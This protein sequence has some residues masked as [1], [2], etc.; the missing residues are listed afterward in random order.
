MKQKQFLKTL[1]LSSPH[2]SQHLLRLLLL[3]VTL[4]GVVSA[5][6]EDVTIKTLDW[7]ASEWSSHSTICNTQKEET[8]NGI[9]FT[10][11]AE[12]SGDG[13][14]ISNGLLTFTSDGNIQSNNRWIAVPLENINGKITVNIAGVSGNKIGVK[15]AF[16]AGSTTIGTPSSLSDAVTSSSNGQ[17][18][19]ININDIS[20]TSGVLY[21]GR[22]SSNYTQIGNVTITTPSSTPS[23]G[24]IKNVDGTTTTWD[25]TKVTQ[26][27]GA[28]LT[29]WTEDT[30]NKYFKNPAE[31]KY[32]TPSWCDGI[33][34][35][36]KGGTDSDKVRVYYGEGTNA[37]GVNFNGNN[38]A[39]KVTIPA[40]ANTLEVYSAQT[41][42]SSDVTLSTITGGYSAIVTPGQEVV[43]YRNSGATFIT[44]VITKHEDIPTYTITYN[45]N[46]HGDAIAD[47]TEA[48]ALPSTLPTPT[49][50][51]Y[52]FGGWY[53]DEGLTNAATAGAAISANTTLYAKWTAQVY[54]IKYPGFDGTHGDNHPT[55]HTYGTATTLVNP[56]KAGY[57]F[58]GW[59]DNQEFTGSAITV[60]GAT[61][62]T[63]NI[64]LY[65]KWTA[66]ASACEISNLKFGETA[67][68]LID[69]IYTVTIAHNDL[70][71]P[72]DGKYYYDVTFNISE[73]AT[74]TCSSGTPKNDNGTWS[75]RKSLGTN[76]GDN[77]NFTLTVT[78]QDG[79]SSNTYS[80][81]LVR[82]S[83]PVTGISLDKQKVYL[84]YNTTTDLV[85][86]VTPD[87]ATNK[88]INWTSSD[89]SN[90]T[91]TNGTVKAKGAYGGS[92]VITATAADGSG[93]SADCN[94]YLYRFSETGTTSKD[95]VVG[96]DVSGVNPRINTVFTDESGNVTFTKD[97][98]TVTSSNSSVI[99][100]S[101]HGLQG[102]NNEKVV[103]DLTLGGSAGEAELYLTYTGSNTN[104]N[105]TKCTIKYTVASA[106]IG[107][108]DCSDAYGANVTSDAYAL[109]EGK[110]V[111]FSFTNHNGAK[112]ESWNNWDLV[113]GY[114]TDHPDQGN[115]TVLRADA[116]Y[117]GSGENGTHCNKSGDWSAMTQ[118]NLDGAHVD[119]EVT[120]VG[121]T[122]TYYAVMTLKDG[123]QAMEDLT[124]TY[125]SVPSHAWLR[126]DNSYISDLD[127]T[128]GDI[129][130][131]TV[132][133]SKN[134]DAA[135]T[136]S[137]KVK[138]TNTEVTQVIN[139]TTVNFT[140]T[141]A[142]GYEFDGWYAGDNLVATEAVY[143]TSV[144]AN[145]NLTAK[146]K[147]LVVASTIW[148]FE[149]GNGNG[150]YTE[151]EM[152][153]V[154]DGGSWNGTGIKLNG[155][156][157]SFTF[158]PNADGVLT[159]SGTI[160]NG[161]TA[162]ISVTQG[163]NAVGYTELSTGVARYNVVAGQP[164]VIKRANSNHRVSQ[165]EFTPTGNI[166]L[167]APQI[168]V[169]NGIVTFTNP[170][171]ATTLY[172]KYD[173]AKEGD[174]A[175]NNYDAYTTLE[176]K[177]ITLPYGIYPADWI[178]AQVGDG[179]K[180][181]AITKYPTEVTV[182]PDV[183]TFAK[184]N[185]AINFTA[186]ERCFLEFHVG[187]QS[188][189]A[190][191]VYSTTA[192]VTLDLSSA[193]K[194][195]TI[196]NAGTPEA[197]LT[198]DL[199]TLYVKTVAEYNLPNSAKD[200]IG[201]DLVEV[202]T[203]ATNVASVS[204][205]EAIEIYVG[206]TLDVTM[207]PTWIDPSGSPSTAA[208]AKRWTITSGT[209][210][211]TLADNV[212]TT[213]KITGQKSNTSDNAIAKLKVSLDGV[214]SNECTVTIKRTPLAVRAD[215]VA[216][217]HN[218]N[219]ART[220]RAIAYN[221]YTRATV[222]VSGTKAEND[223]DL[224]IT[225][226]P[227]SGTSAFA[228][229][230]NNTITPTGT[231]TG[232][233][234][235]VVTAA[236][237]TTAD[238]N[239]YTSGT[240][241]I[242]VTCRDYLYAYS[243]S[244]PATA[245]TARPV[246]NTSHEIALNYFA[247]HNPAECKV[248][249]E[250]TK[251][252]NVLKTWGDKNR[253]PQEQVIA[254]YSVTTTIKNGEEVTTTQKP[255]A[256]I[257]GW[258]GIKN[259]AEPTM[260]SLSEQ[261]SKNASPVYNGNSN[262]TFTYKQYSYS[263]DHDEFNVPVMGSFYRFYPEKNGTLIAY[264]CV[265][266]QFSDSEMAN[267]AANNSTMTGYASRNTYFLD[268]YANS[269]NIQNATVQPTSTIQPGFF[270][271]TLDNCK[272]TANLTK[273]I[274]AL[275]NN[276]AKWGND[277]KDLN[278]KLV[279]PV[280]S[281]S[282]AAGKTSYTINDV[283]WTLFKDLAQDK[284][285]IFHQP[286]PN[287][288]GSFRAITKTYVRCEVPVEKGRVY[289]VSPT[290]TKTRMAGVEFIPDAEDPEAVNVN[291]YNGT[292]SAQSNTAPYNLPSNANQS[293]GF[294][295]DVTMTPGNYY[296]VT[297]ADR[298]FKADQWYSFC[299]PFDV[300]EKQIHDIFGAG[301]VTIHFDN[302]KEENGDLKM[303]FWSHFYDQVRAGR[304]IMIKMPETFPNGG[305]TLDKGAVT[306]QHV[307]YNP[308]SESALYIQ[309]GDWLF[310]GSYTPVAM[311]KNAVI[312]NGTQF[313]HYRDTE[314][315]LAGN[316]A[317]IQGPASQSSNARLI[318]SI[319]SFDEDNNDEET[320]GI[321]VLLSEMGYNVMKSSDKIYNL[322]GQMVGQGADINNLPKG[323]YIVNGKKQI[324]K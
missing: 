131:R 54:E 153:L 112:G 119:V 271:Y 179:A 177:Q 99:S 269:M 300:P 150:T 77:T 293:T 278:G 51:G 304:P 140:A 281:A 206:Q 321:E 264:L 1:G 243:T 248:Y 291:F 155:D 107:A 78:A 292:I 138:D 30:S 218:G 229:S 324:V 194:K 237:K 312:I 108:T 288:D 282:Y 156:N 242:E 139:G 190:V 250:E 60:I 213:S 284:V 16:I 135:G 72:K 180:S 128:T 171:V 204:I 186:P 167:S 126:V 244:V 44:K 280:K 62:I 238:K 35:G 87:D 266:G 289:Y 273:D 142:D 64:N 6:A 181:S 34:I 315:T 276:W 258:D 98:F 210:Y 309:N 141:P 299:M 20:E 26:T 211:L 297:L 43:L 303:N 317:W 93:V 157:A 14:A 257:H 216:L 247:G 256:R 160:S 268:P 122:V 71:N 191:Q 53:T 202:T 168:S 38:G 233:E 249:D 207:T 106:G 3:L 103:L 228:T 323:V 58:D 222:G 37:R 86:T 267:L 251:N 148:T 67:L 200:Y 310:K 193:T 260:N 113:T 265:N 116:W 151:N 81:R 118:D 203:E 80:I 19:S 145:V 209:D 17:S 97:D 173:R 319:S 223:K 74:V 132:A 39:I 144:T 158:T 28:K 90:V 196:K 154:I 143:Q 239:L 40:G 13:Y 73:N 236:P 136:I 100:G 59:Y 68:E 41:I 311:G 220:I 212:R 318:T 296:N 185:T 286:I 234:T 110:T 322:N 169:E 306:F 214:E 105:G 95:F 224:T 170:N 120:K 11:S 261:H 76:A 162:Y 69:G 10:R 164:V 15:Y 114:S 75:M 47:V 298:S 198:F 252:Y 295:N 121:N 32:W 279:I 45:L 313:Y 127:V 96:A 165:I 149:E 147:T 263:G 31:N 84:E 152:D 88:N 283:D 63:A 174:I 56:T 101:V 92:A 262:G 7:S 42:L 308:V 230:S 189:E 89:E 215:H 270:Y 25:F 85:A 205:P 201:S 302:V 5:W 226:A 221:P 307:K 163:G 79:V 29:D 129:T 231:A 24:S 137:A 109:T 274:E 314:K 52:D 18:I 195:M 48:T 12:T 192:T 61:Q 57:T 82:G 287:G 259:V 183:P 184:T 208:F 104:Y 182:A 66:A 55:R 159:V 285:G 277:E 235:W 305:T 255:Y 111:K 27:M 316:R 272:N 65:A 253:G 21:F 124:Y 146:F 240:A 46:G 33:A 133:I 225:A 227:K 290:G 294:Q 301:A 83:N 70:Q 176:T 4:G 172:F 22:S 23:V 320:T 102:S 178:Q 123:R 166:G 246:E 117:W 9:K 91:V 50:T 197:D 232:T 130:Y 217:S 125:T 115:A 2:L 161:T 254:N 245:P 94:V 134:N 187:S 175:V 199:A 8:V 241:E 275:L 219:E 188:A 36:V 49:A